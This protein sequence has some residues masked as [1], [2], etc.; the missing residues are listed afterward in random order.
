SDIVSFATFTNAVVSLLD[1]TSIETFVGNSAGSTLI[2]TDSG[3]NW[4]IDGTNS[5][6]VGTIIFTDFTGLTGGTG[7]DNFAFDN[8]GSVTGTI[9]GG[10]GQDTVDYSLQTTVVVNL[11]GGFNGVINAEI[12][13][14]NG[15]DSTLIG[16]D[17]GDSWSINDIGAGSVAGISFTGFTDLIG[18][19]GND[20][21]SFIN[22]GS[23]SGLVDGGLG[24]DLADYSGQTGAVVSLSNFASVETFA[25]NG[26]D[27]TLVGTD[28]GDSWLIDGTNSGT[29]NAI[30]F[31]DF[32][33]L[34]GG[35]GNDTFTF[36][37]DG[38]INGLIDG[39]LGSDTANFAAVTS[40]IVNLTDFTRVESFVGNN[41]DSTL[42]GTDTGDNWTIDG[43]NSGSNGV[44][45]FTDF[46]DLTGGDGNDTFTFADGGSISGLIDGGLGSDNANF[47]GVTSAIVNLT[48]FTRVESFV[49]NNNDSTLVGTDNGD[50]WL[51]DG[52]NSGTVGTIVFTDFANLTGGAGDD[53]F[54]FT[55]SGSLSGLFDGATGQDTA[56]YSAQSSVNVLLA[57]LL[58][59]ETVIGNDTQSTLVADNISNTWL[60]TNENEGTVDGVAFIGFNNLTGGSDI[61]TFTIQ[62]GGSITGVINGGAGAGIIDILDLTAITTDI[63]VAADESIS[64]D[65]NILDIEQVDANDDSNLS[66]TFLASNT[67]NTWNI[68]GINS[69]LL[70]TPTVSINFSGFENLTG[71]NLNDSFNLNSSDHITGLIEGGGGT[72]SL[73][74]LTLGYDVTVQL[75]AVAGSNLTGTPYINNIE[76]I[77]ANSTRNN[78]LIGNNVE[79]N[80]LIDGANTSTIQEVASSNTIAFT[81]FNNLI[82]GTN[83]DAFEI[84]DTSNLV[85]INGGDGAGNDTIDYSNVM[86]DIDIT[87]GASFSPTGIAIDG[88]E[89]LIGNNDGS[90]SSFNSTITVI[91]GNNIWTIGDFDGAGIADGTNDG[92][93]QDANGDI[94]SFINFN[95]LQGGDG[96]DIFNVQNG[97]SITGF[98]HGGAGADELRLDVNGAGQT[99]FVGGEGVDSVL[100]NGGGSD[101]DAFYTSNVNGDDQLAYTN[102][103]GDTYTFSYDE[104]E[105]VQDDVIATNFTILGSTGVDLIELSTGSVTVNG[106]TALQYSNRTNLILSGGVDD[107]FDLIG[108]LNLG[109]GALTL[110]S[111][112]L[113]NTTGSMI[114]A[115]SLTLNSVNNIGSDAL[116]INTNVNGLILDNVIG[117]V[118]LN[119]SNALEIQGFTTTGIFDLVVAGDVIQSADVIL[120][121]NNE[122][123]IDAVGDINLTNQNELSGSINLSS[124]SDISLTNAVDTNLSGINAQN[125]N[126]N[127]AGNITDSGAIVVGNVMTLEANNNDII[128]DEVNN[129]LNIVNISNT[130]NATLVNSGNLT[131]NSIAV[132]GALDV[133][134]DNLLTTDSVVANSINLNATGQVQINGTVESI[135]GDININA[136]EIVQNASIN[137]SNDI[138]LASQQGIIMAS[139]A[140]ST[141]VGNINYTATNDVSISL[142]T[143]TDG[144]V[145]I[146]SSNGQIIDNNADSDNIVANRA[147][148]TS[149]NGIGANDALETQLVYLF[150]ENTLGQVNFNNRGSITIERL[151]T[152]GD[153]E[154][155]NADMNG[156][157]IHITA[158]SIDAGYDV[159][160]LLMRTEG[161]SFLGV[162]DVPSFEN[163]DIV[164]R[165]ATFIDTLFEGTFGSVIRPLV[166]RV[167]DVVNISVRT[168]FSPLFDAPLPEIND[169]DSLFSFSSL[170]TLSALAGGQLV[171][172]ES[173]VEVDPA[174]FTDL[175]NYNNHEVAVKLPND[176]LFDYAEEEEEE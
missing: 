82:G 28:S 133:S 15:S 65:F 62:S 140:S 130:N 13:Q 42:I 26:L 46:T 59:I 12:I 32:I 155:N 50:S 169:S 84:I 22:T 95:I 14:G 47:A 53:T 164:A 136:N 158:G 163:A 87:I 96:I 117:D 88:I 150:A 107:T 152:S 165:S 112:S 33:N 48:D 78:T 154:F 40:A 97:G 85:S 71:G 25:G 92:Q 144:T 113:T 44:I 161:G 27:S 45:V 80:W 81:G 73:N 74:M 61:D 176:Q 8:G 41:T 119:E 5:G 60:I 121:S 110:N 156:S 129:N 138:F 115:D 9:D 89:G 104:V 77:S 57:D 98:I 79:T 52:A 149:E 30:I 16:T 131:L 111:S 54:A 148:L 90:N 170:D 159:G 64:A 66:N 105:T 17:N 124:L 7:D 173:L 137:S 135:S 38:S 127:V 172:V 123:V 108:D 162:G 175:R 75:G 94:V 21:F 126:L 1:Y 122:F 99:R 83:D 142:L 49:G 125:F 141:A 103:S 143:T 70:N 76:S 167:R 118:Y 34:T 100:L 2:G 171:E 37:N 101:Y 145:T 43:V 114:T 134:T 3:D 160:A 116:R 153:I 10:L 68:N 23:I 146:N 102:S 35:A 151:A 166:L 91:D 24:N 69:G 36:D 55:D 19:I 56:D 6:T 58:S 20:I 67:N 132:N 109:S 139:N 147:V 63:S 93:F 86:A 120:T 168:S 4:T 128:F 106:A 29:V 31:S 72:D 39:G 11:S 174:I 18:G 157:D 51:I